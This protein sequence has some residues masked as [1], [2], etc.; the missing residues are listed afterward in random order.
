[1]WRRA[2]MTRS[3]TTS[4]A[5]ASV[6]RRRSSACRRAVSSASANG[7]TREAAAPAC[8]PATRSSTSSRADRMQTGTSMPSP[9]RRRSTLTPSRSGIVT[10]ST[11]TAGGRRATAS[12]ASRPPAAVSTAKPS[13]RRA[14]SRACRIVASSSTTRTSGSGVAVA[15]SEP[16]P[17]E[18]AQRVLHLGLVEVELLRQRGDEGV[19]AGLELLHGV[20][21]QR[22]ERVAQLGR[23]HAELGGQRVERRATVALAA[24]R[25][26]GA[27]RVAQLRRADA[28]LLG[29]GVEARAVALGAH[30]LERRVDLRLV[31]SER[32]GE[33]GAELGVLG[34]EVA[35][36]RL[37][38]GDGNV[39]RVGE[40]GGHLV[41]RVLLGLE[42]VPDAAQRVA[43]RGGRD[44]ELVGQR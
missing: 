11:I 25:A 39:E 19:A 15:R 20:R 40:L 27:Q 22:L 23:G 8:S 44:A 32:L 41:A 38:L 24:V 9:R 3:P 28:E 14:R 1:M 33:V 12:S 30:L 26:Q 6:P 18:G 7:L 2:S 4:A 34:L 35:E 29:E 17:A 13:S 10:S 16:R 36:G 43:Q 42:L 5:V 31:K 37:D 21:A